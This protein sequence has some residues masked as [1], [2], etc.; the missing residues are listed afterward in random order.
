MKWLCLSVKKK[1]W[2]ICCTVSF[3]VV[4][5]DTQAS[6]IHET[7]RLWL[8]CTVSGGLRVHRHMNADKLAFEH[9]CITIFQHTVFKVNIMYTGLCLGE[10]V[11]ASVHEHAR[12]CVGVCMLIRWRLF[13]VPPYIIRPDV[14]SELQTTRPQ[15]RL[16]LLGSVNPTQQQ[17]IALPPA[18]DSHLKP[19]DCRFSNTFKSDF[20]CF[21]FLFFAHL[22]LQV[23]YLFQQLLMLNCQTVFSAKSVY[24]S[25][26]FFFIF[27]LSE[28]NGKI[29]I[30]LILALQGKAMHQWNLN[31]CCILLLCCCDLS[32][33]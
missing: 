14:S 17:V 28:M 6:F 24:F 30:A 33:F 13:A 2:L 29:A 16:S 8:Q 10:H 20:L 26:F 5:R 12:V 15:R 32:D 27:F 3:I 25:K 31:S 18:A 11:C 22:H 7:G 4:G 1:S 9:H 21:L 19:L 23:Y